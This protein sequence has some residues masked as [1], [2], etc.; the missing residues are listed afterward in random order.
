MSNKSLN[1]LSENSQFLQLDYQITYDA[2][3]HKSFKKL[4]SAIKNRIEEL[5]DL[6]QVHPQRV[7][8]SLLDFIQKYPEVPI[9]YN[10]LT[11]AYEATGQRKKAETLIKEAYQ[12]HP[13]YL[14]AKT[15]YALYC[16]RTRTA[17]K[18]PE[19]FEHQFDLKLLYPRRNTF[20]ITEFISF[21]TVMALYHHAMA[22]RK[23]AVKYYEIV[24]K[25]EPNHYLTAIIK[26]QLYPTF[27]QKLRDKF[28]RY[29]EKLERR[30]E[31]KI[32]FLDEADK[33]DK[34]DTVDAVEAK[35]D[36]YSNYSKEF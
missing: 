4:P 25:L 27:F 21:N 18:I 16:L 14:F 23:S 17:D 29:L 35:S 31:N 32:E 8:A 20:H 24:Q 12:K 7:I 30:L 10:Y 13:D 6:T 2:L 1:A 34:V 3:P 36:K 5:H 26:R 28:V 19:I 11:A 9:F 33:V 22:H 15:N